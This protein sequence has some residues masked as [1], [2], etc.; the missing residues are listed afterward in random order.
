[1]NAIALFAGAGVKATS[2]QLPQESAVKYLTSHGIE[3][4]LADCIAKLVKLGC[5]LVITVVLCC[6]CTRF[7][8]LVIQTR[9]DESFGIAACAVPAAFHLTSQVANGLC[10]T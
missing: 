3:Q 2:D 7:L 1:M 10:S 5:T 8:A 6:C 9:Y 4:T